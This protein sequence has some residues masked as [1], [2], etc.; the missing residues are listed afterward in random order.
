MYENGTT[1]LNMAHSHK[2]E[3]LPVFQIQFD[4]NPNAD[5]MEQLEAF[6]KLS[7]SE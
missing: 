5:A 6:L 3:K 2:I 7:W 4:G 1:I